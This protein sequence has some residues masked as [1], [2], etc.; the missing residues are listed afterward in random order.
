MYI[1]I[2]KQAIEETKENLRLALKK[3]DIDEIKLYAQHIAVLIKELERFENS[4][5]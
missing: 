5:K 2:L 4:D 1:Q 3:N